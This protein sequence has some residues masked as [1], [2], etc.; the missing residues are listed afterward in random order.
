MLALLGGLGARSLIDRWGRWAQVAIAATL[1]EGIVSVGVMM[2][3]PLSYF[4]PLIGGLP[5]GAALGME[6]TYYWDA[7]SPEACQWLSA[8]TE[9]PDTIRFASFPRSWLYLRHIR[10]LPDRLVPIDRGQPKWY[11]LQNRPGAFH[12]HDRPLIAHGRPAYTVT[13][14][15]VPLIWIYPFSEL[16]RVRAI[17]AGD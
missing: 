3:A 14:L 16:E 15:G 5:G 13:K 7:L 10:A 1:L 11:V 9:A 17:P 2:P 4:S 6:P 12:P 8:H